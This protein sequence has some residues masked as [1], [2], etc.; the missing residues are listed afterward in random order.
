MTDTITRWEC[1]ECGRQTSA[2][3]HVPPIE[4]RRDWWC[5]GVP[6]ERTYVAVDALLSGKAHLA[7]VNTYANQ[8][9]LS[10]TGMRA[11]LGAEAVLEAAIN[12]ITEEATDVCEECHGT[13]DCHAADCHPDGARHD[14]S[15]CAATGEKP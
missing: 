11:T 2:T 5:P 14:C 9:R 12:A 1:P 10:A 3:V 4:D 15:S 6:V 8:E 13:G 7:A